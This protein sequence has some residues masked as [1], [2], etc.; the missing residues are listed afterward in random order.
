VIPVRWERIQALF[1][2]ALAQPPAARL[3]SPVGLQRDRAAPEVAS[4][5]AAHERGGGIESLPPSG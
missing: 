4:L 5:L 2:E 1:E 3:V